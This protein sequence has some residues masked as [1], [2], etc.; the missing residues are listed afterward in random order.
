MKTKFILTALFA[1]NASASDLNIEP[2]GS[3]KCTWGP[4]YWCTSL[5]EAAEC[6]THQYCVERQW[7]NPVRDDTLCD[8][9]KSVAD[10]AMVAFKNSEGKIKETLENVCSYTS[11]FDSCKKIVD[12]NWDQIKEMIEGAV[13]S[14]VLCSAMNM[15]QQKDEGFNDFQ[16]QLMA[17]FAGPLLQ[18]DQVDFETS[19]AEHHVKFE[20][21]A[22]PST[23]SWSKSSSKTCT[24]CVQFG[25]DVKAIVESNEKLDQ[26]VETIQLVCDEIEMRSLCRLVLNRKVIKK[27]IDKVDI[28]DIC[29]QGELCQADDSPVL[30]AA[31]DSCPDCANIINDLK[32][33][34]KNDF[35]KFEGMIRQAC[36][37]IPHPVNDMCKKMA[38]RFAEE[39][40]ASLALADTE[41]CCEAISL[42]EKASVES[43]SKPSIPE[44]LLLPGK[45][46][47][48]C[49][50]AVEYIQ[51]AVDSDMTSDQ[52]KAGL[53]QLCDKLQPNSVAQ[54]CEEFVDKYWEQ[55]VDDMDMILND[56]EHVCEK[57]HLCKKKTLSRFMYQG[58]VVYPPECTYG[59]EYWCASDE[60]MKK[61]GAEDF[62]K[63][64]LL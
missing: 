63:K 15:C 29:Q 57:M 4:S 35:E 11:D 55:L 18:P 19:D 2:L 46:C 53:K 42:C 34:A 51:Y 27:I 12:E 22:K 36:D 21:E 47:D 40:A 43:F 54:T 10:K 61:C 20:S 31:G 64:D 13:D 59:P 6:S 49:E 23:L 60:N 17:G 62:C 39:A 1:I 58:K 56:P 7:V 3:K 44:E 25:V 33:L 8:L 32:D 16:L 38:A 5:S 30:P 14:Q 41:E 48:Y 24:D 45:Y 9:C 52:I 28:V 50:T 37:L 26:L